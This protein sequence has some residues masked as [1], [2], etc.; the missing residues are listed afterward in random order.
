MNYCNSY[1]CENKISI[2]III[3]IIRGTEASF[4]LIW[5]NHPSKTS[6][7]RTVVFSC[8][9][10]TPP[11][12]ML[13][14]TISIT[15]QNTYIYL[16]KCLDLS[17]IEYFLRI[18]VLVQCLS[19]TFLLQH[20]ITA[21]RAQTRSNLESQDKAEISLKIRPGTHHR[22]IITSRQHSSNTQHP[23]ECKELTDPREIIQGLSSIV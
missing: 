18:C 3:I 13:T 17:E 9:K 15:Q 19:L 7:N 1:H 20:Y 16:Y 5:I 12:V 23:D 8:Q 6:L 4:P 21:Q 11:A 10:K 22:G 2:I 14:L